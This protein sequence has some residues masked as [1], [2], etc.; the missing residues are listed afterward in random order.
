MLQFPPKFRVQESCKDI[1]TTRHRDHSTV[2]LP[3]T[4]RVFGNKSLYTLKS[5]GKILRKNKNKDLARLFAILYLAEN[6]K[7]QQN[8]EPVPNK[9]PEK[10]SQKAKEFNSLFEIHRVY[11]LN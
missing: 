4:N 10:I 6:R 5:C 3:H 1:N 9:C 11:K 7:T 8:M 2:C